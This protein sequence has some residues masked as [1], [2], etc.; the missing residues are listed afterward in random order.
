MK[1]SG[2]TNQGIQRI[3]KVIQGQEEPHYDEADLDKIAKIIQLLPDYFGDPSSD[4]DQ[5]L[6]DQINNALASVIDRYTGIDSPGLA[7]NY[8]WNH[9]NIYIQEFQEEFGLSIEEIAEVYPIL[10]EQA[11]AMGGVE[12]EREIIEEAIVNSFSK[13]F[14]DDFTDIE[15][16]DEYNVEPALVEEIK[17]IITNEWPSI[18]AD[19]LFDPSTGSLIELAN[20]RVL[21]TRDMLELYGNEFY[22]AAKKLQEMVNPLIEGT[23]YDWYDFS[24]QFMDFRQELITEFRT[25]LRKYTTEFVEV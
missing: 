16:E 3:A 24:S 9:L 2:I 1:L 19:M 25:N 14:S 20:D 15:S 22:N 7:I 11:E 5:N 12:G 4:I 10:S 6:I 17:N 13:H 8:F 21:N 23:D 18:V